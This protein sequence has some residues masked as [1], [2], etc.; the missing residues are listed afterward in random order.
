VTAQTPIGSANQKHPEILTQ[1]TAGEP[2]GSTA[3]PLV[4]Q[5]ACSTPEDVHAAS[6]EL[7]SS[8]AEDMHPQTPR[9]AAWLY[10]GLVLFNFGIASAFPVAG[11]AH[12]TPSGILA[13][14]ALVTIGLF[15]RTTF[16][17]I[18]A[19]AWRYWAMFTLIAT[20]GF[21]GYNNLVPAPTPFGLV[22]TLIVAVLCLGVLATLAAPPLETWRA[23]A[24]VSC[25]I[26]GAVCLVAAKQ[27]AWPF[28]GLAINAAIQRAALPQRDFLDKESG[29]KIH[30]TGD[31]VQLST[32]TSWLPTNNAKAVFFHLSSQQLVYLFDENIPTSRLGPTTSPIDRYLDLVLGARRKAF[33]DI[34]E[35][36]PRFWTQCGPMRAR[37][38]G[39]A[40]SNK[41][42]HF[43]GALIAFDD[44]WSW[45][46]F[47]STCVG[48]ESLRAQTALGELQRDVSSTKTFDERIAELAK[49]LAPKFPYFSER[50]IDLF[51]RQVVLKR[52][53]ADEAMDFGVQLTN[54][55][56]QLLSVD[57]QQ[58][59]RELVQNAIH[60]L[61]QT[62]Q[63]EMG[64]LERVAS[65]RPMDAAAKQAV[66]QWGSLFITAIGNL[67][68]QDRWRLQHLFEREVVLAI[69]GI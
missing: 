1:P 41:G 59:F 69:G 8:V 67:N 26:L 21:A 56:F 12:A 19:G 63:G 40:W 15:H 14:G 16:L 65:K 46:L 38:M 3:C 37:G 27:G 24:G 7:S 48:G 30:L 6:S 28:Q 22:A 11:K 45:W 18:S 10:L 31:W 4:P 42:D 49:E 23:A 35:T 34:V 44:G 5:Q 43:T 51:T 66:N 17:R 39:I 20:I 64:N 61:S 47:S 25:C 50:A 29:I 68:Q 9:L 58:E 57:E 52:L 62:Q 32:T 13:F 2:P 36:E 55:G 54:R 33:P 60:T 53:A